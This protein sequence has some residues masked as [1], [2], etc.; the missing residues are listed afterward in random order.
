MIFQYLGITGAILLFYGMVAFALTRANTPFF[1]GLV[2]VGLVFLVIFV[3]KALNRTWQ[4]I[5]G[6]FI[7]LNAVWIGAYFFIKD[8]DWS[9]KALAVSALVSNLV[10]LWVAK[11]LL[12]DLFQKRGMR[13]GTTAAIYSVIVGMILIVINIGSQDFNK[14]FDFTA[15]RIN[16]LSDQTIKVASELEDTVKITAF[17]DGQNQAKPVAKMMLDRYKALGK[18]I[19]VSFVD[20]DQEKLLAE[21]KK[22][23]DGDIVIEYK[24]QSH[25]TQELTEQGIT[26]AILKVTRSDSPIVCFTSGHGELSLDAEP[27]N[28]RSISALKDGLANEGYQPKTLQQLG[29]ELPPE[30]VMLVIAGPQQRFAQSEIDLVDHYLAGGGKVIAMLDPL[31]SNSKLAQKSFTVQPSG[32]EE[33][34]KKWGIKLG[35]NIMLEKHLSLYQ[36]VQADLS[37]R[38]MN[39][40]NHPIVDS[41]KGKQTVFD[42][43]QSVQKQ[44]GFVGQSYELIKSAGNGNSWAETNIDYLYKAKKADPDGQDILGPVDIAMAS[45]KELDNKKKV[46][47][48]VFGDSDFASNNLINSYEFNYDL[49]LNAMN[50]MVGDAK[51]ISIRAK[52]IKTSAI[53]LSPEESNMIFYIAIISIPMVILI[54]GIN[55]WWF[56]RRKG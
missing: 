47:L 23:N 26:Q 34:L 5:I 4:K 37:V 56:R 20:P 6:L 40:G 10:F 52:K 7:G 11:T 22:A 29:Q 18:K 43:V 27:E 46:Q 24:N 13:T 45:E 38:S 21:Q 50:W 8:K 51:K 55:L 14:Q 48:I 30:C 25:T 35:N 53:E 42:N 49:V 28:P 36:G 32:F 31:L 16:T 54:F 15:E 41:L 19:D 9:N 3:V 44:G 17:Y 2:G 39:Y 12:K 33:M 1:K